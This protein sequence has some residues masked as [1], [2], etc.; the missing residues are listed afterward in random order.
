[1]S[2]PGLSEYSAHFFAISAHAHV[3]LHPVAV[4][5][6]HKLRNNA[7]KDVPSYGM[8]SPYPAVILYCKSNYSAFAPIHPLSADVHQNCDYL[9]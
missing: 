6:F 7:E 1:M 5:H 2:V 3:S 9:S 8:F 4:T